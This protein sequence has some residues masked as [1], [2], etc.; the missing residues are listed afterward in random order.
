MTARTDVPSLRGL[1][2]RLGSMIDQVGHP[3]YSLRELIAGLR[4]V[5]DDLLFLWE[6]LGE[7][8]LTRDTVL[9]E[10]AQRCNTHRL[11]MNEIGNR[12]AGDASAFLENAIRALK[13][14]AGEQEKEK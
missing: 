2:D 11:R 13:T 3:D 14:N 1:H 8:E 5:R 7:K 9:E 6:T 10:A 4:E 12:P